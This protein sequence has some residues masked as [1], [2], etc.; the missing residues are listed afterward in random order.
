[1]T[2]G[3]TDA[4]HVAAADPL[5]A[6]A[7]AGAVVRGGGRVTPLA[8]ATGLVCALGPDGLRALLDASSV[9]WVQLGGA[10]IEAFRG[11]LDPRLTWTSAKGA[12]AEPVAEHALA[13]ALAVL[14]RF[15]ERARAR[16]WGAQAG[17]S[18]FGRRV[19]VVGG[20]GIAS[21]LVRLLQPYRTDIT[22]VRR[23]RDPLP[24]ASR[25]VALGELD[26]HLPRTDVLVLAAALTP[27]TAGLMDARR[28]A[29]LPASAVVVNIAR[30]GLID[31][32][33]LVA[34]LR[35]GA[36]AGAGLDV[37]DPEPLPAGHPLWDEPRA[38]VTPHT[39]DTPEMIR[40]MLA[41]R[42]EENVRRRIA[43]EPLVGVVDTTLGY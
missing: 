11:T 2:A 22:V 10:G 41:A 37:T 25:T 38:L 6:E 26:E 31:T 9:D 32:D 4:V 28:L 34:A 12:Y 18:L 1:M 21:E 14:R 29:L 43:G 27:E 33:A 36:I 23:S 30:G 39:A 13:L 19:L 8:E 16:E 24:G 15:T 42:V 7:L 3:R 35:D 20:G 17:E 40:V 5:L